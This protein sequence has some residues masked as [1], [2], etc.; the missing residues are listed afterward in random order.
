MPLL[1]VVVASIA[2]LIYA[3]HKS[4]KP[5]D[6]YD[7]SVSVKTITLVP[8]SVTKLGGYVCPGGGRLVIDSAELA[9]LGTPAVDITGDLQKKTLTP[10]MGPR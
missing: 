2:V 10:G 5:P 6:T 4:S 8:N 3:F 9:A 7:E 1:G